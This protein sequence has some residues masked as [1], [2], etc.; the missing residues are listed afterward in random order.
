MN[1]AFKK[2][3]MHDSKMHFDSLKNRYQNNLESMKGSEKVLKIDYVQLFY[4]KC[5]KINQN[6]G[7][8]YIDSPDRI[9]NKKNNNKSHQKKR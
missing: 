7:V 5:Y 3:M 2:C 1:N 6:C 4:Y 9:K 8:S